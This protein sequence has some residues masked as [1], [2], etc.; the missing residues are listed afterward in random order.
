MKFLIIIPAH[1]EEKNIFFTLESLKNQ[2]FKDFEIVVVNDG[3]TDKTG[4]IVE[5]FKSQIPNLKL[6]NLEKS[7]HEPGAKVVNTFNK[8]LKS[9]DVQ[10]FDI[11]CKFDADIIF[12]DNYLKKVN[13]VYETN[14]KAGMVSG[15][16]KIK[17]SVFE[18]NLAFDFKGEK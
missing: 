6:L 12:P 18:K 4:E 8:G 5:N 14:P 15:L 7:V 3:S 11:I 16:V 1:N 9:V 17:K 10:S 2:I 13:E